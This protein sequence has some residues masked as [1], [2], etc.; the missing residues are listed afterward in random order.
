MRESWM[1]SAE[2]FVPYIEKHAPNTWWEMEGMA[3]GAELDFEDI[4]ILASV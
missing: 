3:K 1:P 4:L 2:R